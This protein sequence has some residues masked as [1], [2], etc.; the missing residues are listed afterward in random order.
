[1]KKL[2]LLIKASPFA[3][4][5]VVIIIALIMGACSIAICGR[6]NVIENLAEEMVEHQLNLP[7]GSIDKAIECIEQV[8]IQD[9]DLP[10]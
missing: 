4:S 3:S 7:A 10:K 8:E 5:I 1:V 2:L 6:N 9:G